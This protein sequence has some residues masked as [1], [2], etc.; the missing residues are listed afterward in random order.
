MSKRK[1]PVTERRR[2]HVEINLLAE[3]DEQGGGHIRT[4]RGCSLPFFGGVLGAWLVPLGL[5]LLHG[6]FT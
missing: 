4:R 6:I 2:P 5:L 3:D 1:Q